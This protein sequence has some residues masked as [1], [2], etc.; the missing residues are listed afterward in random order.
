V[1]PE[2]PEVPVE[3]EVASQRLAARWER[4]PTQPKMRG[5]EQPEPDDDAD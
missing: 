5:H 4:D 1:K 2:K 3:V